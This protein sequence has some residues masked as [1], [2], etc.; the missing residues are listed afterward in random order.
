VIICETVHYGAIEHL[1]HQENRTRPLDFAGDLPM[2]MCWHASDPSRQN[3]AAFGDEFLEQIRI[4]VIDGFGCNIDPAA[5]H[6]AVCP[7]EVRSAFGVFRFHRLFHLPMEGAPAQERIVL[8]LFQ[9]AGRIRA[10]LVTCTYI[11]R[12]RFAFRFRLG[13]LKSNNFPWH[14]S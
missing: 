9:T 8:L 13:A 6:N 14:D 10:L 5:R 12:N 4:L 7:P 2:E 1:L 3:L 11:A